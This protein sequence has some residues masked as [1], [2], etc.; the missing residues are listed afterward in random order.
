MLGE[1]Y[2]LFPLLHAAPD[3]AAFEFI[4]K[5]TRESGGRLQICILS[6]ERRFI[7]VAVENNVL[8]GLANS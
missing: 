7:L 2:S 1:N 5:G 6:W 3:C 8:S 4:R